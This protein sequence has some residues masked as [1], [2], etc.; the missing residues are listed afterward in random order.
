MAWNKIN[1]NNM[2]KSLLD[3]LEADWIPLTQSSNVGSHEYKILSE[4]KFRF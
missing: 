1:Q 3:I 2:I 4:Y